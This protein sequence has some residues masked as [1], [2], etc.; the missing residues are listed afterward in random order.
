MD[1][2]FGKSIIPTNDED[3]L[4]SLQSFNIVDSEPE[5]FFNN[6][7]QIIAQ[8][9]GTPI[10]LISLVDKEHVFFKANVG[11][12]GTEYT[13]RGVSLCALAILDPE[14]TI[15][16]DA[17]KEPCLLANP[18]VAG[19]FGLRFYAGAPI[20]TPDGYNIGTVCVVDKTPRSFG[21]IDKDLLSRFATTVM[22]AIIERK[23]RI[24][25]MTA[26]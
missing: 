19:E 10:A 5:L 25:T 18:L 21:E 7:A 16:E 24:D 13:S 23:V 9:F 3:R 12:E 17:L 6:M 1:N 4:R 20:I 2:T 26:I 11:M 15:F 14:P 8:S 22:E